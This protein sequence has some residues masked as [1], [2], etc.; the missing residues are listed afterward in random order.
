MSQALCAPCAPAGTELG[1]ATAL[2]LHRPWW[3]RA[4]SALLDSA[5][6]LLMRWQRDEA[7]GDIEHALQAL[8]GRT[9]RD[10]GL[11]EL[12]ARREAA[13]WADIERARW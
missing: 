6:A 4:A 11:G 13:L 9:L 7:R 2:P 5:H 3:D 1:F 12:A 8:D 10:L